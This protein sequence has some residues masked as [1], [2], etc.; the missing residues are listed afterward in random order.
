MNALD[1]ITIQQILIRRVLH[2]VVDG[3][4]VLDED[5]DAA[6]KDEEH[7]DDA[8]RSDGIQANEEICAK[9]SKRRRERARA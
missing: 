4:D 5:K 2:E 3:F 8:E 9:M 7:G 6:R 1:A